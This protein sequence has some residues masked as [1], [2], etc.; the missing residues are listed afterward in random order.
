[1]KISLSTIIP[2]ALIFATTALSSSYRDIG[3][4]K[5]ATI[6]YNTDF[7]GD[8]LCAEINHGQEPTLTAAFFS[9]TASR[10]I[11]GFTL[12]SG[13]KLTQIKQCQLQMQRPVQ[14]VDGAYVLSVSEIMGQWDAD[15]VSG[16]TPLVPG[17]VVGSVGAESGERPGPI[18]V[19]QACKDAKNGALSLLVDSS[20]PQVIFPSMKTGAAATLRVYTS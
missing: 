1:M 11:L 8:T 4:D 18:D 16:V 17:K 6:V 13:M 10:I 12:P 15:T 2:S 5:D 7:C 19:T 14:D 9:G 3:A 20:G